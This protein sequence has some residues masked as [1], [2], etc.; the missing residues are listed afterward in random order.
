MPCGDQASR[1]PLYTP[2]GV[3]LLVL[4]PCTPKPR[5]APGA[6]LQRSL[7]KHD[8]HRQLM[9]SLLQQAAELLRCAAAPVERK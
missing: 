9:K 6:E 7:W 2:R 5:E 1:K 4:A 3:P 8:P